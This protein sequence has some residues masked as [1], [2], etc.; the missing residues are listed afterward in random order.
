[1]KKSI[2][3]EKY[4]KICP[5]CGSIDVQTDF[6]NPADWALG[7]TP[8]YKCNSCNHESTIFPEVL[9]DEIENYKKTKSKETNI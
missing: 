1:M 7:I 9:V 2:N 4:V 8:R 5:K 6:S 3:K